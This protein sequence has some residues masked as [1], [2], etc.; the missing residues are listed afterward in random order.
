M[1]G[2]ED[3]P[4]IMPL[5]LQEL[6]NKI[7]EFSSEREYKVKLW[8]I[9]IYNENI[10]DLLS[11][12]D[13]N[14]DLREDPNKGISIANISE[15]N[16]TSCKDIMQILKRGNKNRTQEATN[17]NETSSRSHAILQV[18]IEFKEKSA[19]LE[20]EIK[21]GKLSLIDLAGSERA[22]A[23]QNRGIR[24]IEGANINRSLL[25][26]GNCINALFEASE[27]GSK[28]Y[29][30][31]RDSKLTR[32]LKDS[33]GGNSRTVMIANVSPSVT[34]FDDT[35]N[36]LKYA[37]RAKNIK[38]Q[39]HR[40]VMNVQYHISN[41]NN[42]INNLKNEI[43]DLKI[44]LAKAQKPE[45]FSNP[46]K[47]HSN[48]SS[49]KE[50]NKEVSIIKIPHVNSNL[51]EKCLSELKSHCDEEV[52]LKNKIIEFEQEIFNFQSS[53]NNENFNNSN[54][55][56]LNLNPNVNNLIPHQNNKKICSNSSKDL[57]I[58]TLKNHST[59][60]NT[61]LQQNDYILSANKEIQNL[62][63]LTVDNHVVTEENYEMLIDDKEEPVSMI[64]PNDLNLQLKDVNKPAS[65][66]IIDDLKKTLETFQEKLKIL[67]NRRTTL[68][69]SY[70]K[71]G[72]KDFYFEHLQTLLKTHNSKLLL[73]DNKYKEKV[74]E[75][76]IGNRDS[77]IR[78]LE[79]QIRLRDEVIQKEGINIMNI[80]KI[81]SEMSQLNSLGKIKTIDEVKKEYSTKL[82]LIK[83]NKAPQDCHSTR[84]KDWKKFPQMNLPQINE[85]SGNHAYSSQSI[86]N[87]INSIM[88]DVNK[89][90][91]NISRLD[92]NVR[93][94]ELVLKR[95][96]SKLKGD[97]IIGG[98]M[99]VN[100]NNLNSQISH[101]SNNNSRINQ[102][103]NYSQGIRN[104]NKSALQHQ[105]SGVKSGLQN[106]QSAKNK[107]A[108]NKQNLDFV[109]YHKDSNSDKS[110]NISNS[111]KENSDMMEID[112]QV[113][114]IS[115]EDLM[116]NQFKKRHN[117][118]RDN[119]KYFNKE[120]SPQWVSPHY[121]KDSYI[122][123][124]PNRREE[125]FGNKY[126]FQDHQPQ[127]KKKDLNVFLNDK[128]LKLKNQKKT[129][130]KI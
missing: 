13:E 116:K 59:E 98:N 41:Y 125:S 106:K 26:L 115:D 96:R 76:L 61:N 111:E 39:V 104:S 4:G 36:T 130:F 15:L 11:N 10:R 86:S 25:T 37:N 33:L 103:R 9:E 102:V 57:P 127:F 47:D 78:E 126:N 35:Y 66:Q 105:N 114:N 67:T 42:V 85:L 87:Q 44:Q 93:D 83:S 62:N 34:T 14:L 2:T 117:H 23:T 1:L 58:A 54:I 108:Y 77:H 88:T 31:Y 109:K 52:A 68:M 95:D 12:S 27:K 122:L 6:F 118:F 72:I 53:L 123:N 70:F 48:I 92:G 124:K 5:T 110:I 94:K 17:A 80:N 112:P 19:G 82:P 56:G 90:N 18:H 119:K 60:F 28:P 40:N 7:D 71:L 101:N 20:V 89:I 43:T 75:S 29:V 64:V 120:E 16:V 128:H 65:K 8:Y 3:N 38:T 46:N 100:S 45:S 113:N 51:F 121:K 73:I 69:N 74:Q 30:P 84:P 79:E 24:L 55:N 129:P 81:Q 91:Q 50:E 49:K 22:S 63:Q 107:N 99:N 32:L 21:Q 97:M